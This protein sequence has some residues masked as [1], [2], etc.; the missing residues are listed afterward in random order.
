[1]ILPDPARGPSSIMLLQDLS[2]GTDEPVSLLESILPVEMLHADQVK[3]QQDRLLS[4]LCHGSSLLL[5]DKEE[6]P[7]VGQAGQVIRV[8]P[9]VQVIDIFLLFIPHLPER[10][11]QLSNLI[12]ALIVQLHIIISRGK[13]AGRRSQPPERMREKPHRKHQNYRID[14]NHD[15]HDQQNLFDQSLPGGVDLIDRRGEYQLHAVAQR[16]KGHLSLHAVTRRVADQPAAAL[17]ILKNFL[18]D[19]QARSLGS[20]TLLQDRM[21]EDMPLLIK[22]AGKSCLIYPDGPNLVDQRIQRNI[23]SQDSDQRPRIVDRYKVR[24][25]PHLIQKVC[26][27]GPNPGRAPSLYR[28]EVP[29]VM[30]DVFRIKG[31]RIQR[32][33]R[34]ESRLPRP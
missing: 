19:R 22:Q 33:Q 27:I 10:L 12:P 3:I 32:F 14:K 20:S 23:H 7:H 5:R 26:R 1:M 21:I 17:L 18:L 28:R 29:G 16:G 6:G 24:T 34:N 9:P 30:L 8:N 31:T 4:F 2:Y 15:Q 11:C 25:D 13:I